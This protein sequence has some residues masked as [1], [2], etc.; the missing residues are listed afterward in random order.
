MVVLLLEHDRQQNK[1]QKRWLIHNKLDALSWSMLGVSDKSILRP[2]N[3]QLSLFSFSHWWKL[4]NRSFLSAS[5]SGTD[6]LK[7]E[8]ENCGKTENFAV[9][10]T[11]FLW[12][13]IWWKMVEESEKETDILL[14]ISCSQELKQVRRDTM[15]NKIYWKK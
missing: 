10:R 4:T 14:L 2:L 12:H 5:L 15:E 1:K 9:F 11:L 6:W 8:Y 3:G 7:L 13:L